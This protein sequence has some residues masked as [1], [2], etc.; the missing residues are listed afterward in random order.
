M[1]FFDLFAHFTDALL[2]VLFRCLSFLNEGPCMISSSSFSF[3]SFV[4]PLLFVHLPSLLGFCLLAAAAAASVS[5]LCL[6]PADPS[7][8]EV[9]AIAA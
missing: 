3:F 7:L 4:P 9:A 8:A 2:V 6:A 5:R 1:H